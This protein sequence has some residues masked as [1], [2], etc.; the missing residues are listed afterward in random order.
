MKEVPNHKDYFATEDGI[1]YSLKFGKVRKLKV[2]KDQ[3]GYETVKVDGK[4]RKVH[5][6]VSAAFIGDIT[7]LV[8]RHMNAVRDDNRVSNLKLGTIQDNIN[9]TVR[10]GRQAKGE[11]CGVSKLTENDIRN[12][13]VMLGFEWMTQARIANIYSVHNSVISR[14]KNK[15]AWSHVK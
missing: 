5:R 4:W 10:M 2:T 15:K 11:G 7:G 9:D 3:H 8:V 14:I 1:I 12:I 6:L 13:R